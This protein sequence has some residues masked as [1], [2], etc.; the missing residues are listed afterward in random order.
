MQHENT[1][2]VTANSQIL[3]NGSL[4]HH[5]PSPSTSR[6]CADARSPAEP[7]SPLRRPTSTVARYGAE[8]ISTSLRIPDA[9]TLR[10]VHVR[11]L[12]HLD[13]RPTLPCH[14]PHRRSP[15]DLQLISR[16]EYQR[17]VLCVP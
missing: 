6:V 14:R 8:T 9:R 10:F 17:A 16:G 1:T 2:A 13:L 15:A 11:T 7:L 5:S 12:L 3:L 4:G